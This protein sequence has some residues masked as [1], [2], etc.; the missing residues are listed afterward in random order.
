MIGDGGEKHYRLS[1]RFDRRG[2]APRIELS[3]DDGSLVTDDEDKKSEQRTLLPETLYTELCLY[4]ELTHRRPGDVI[5]MLLIDFL[6]PGTAPPPDPRSLTD[7]LTERADAAAARFRT[8][9]LYP[10]APLEEYQTPEERKTTP[11][12]QD[13]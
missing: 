2:P 8:R 9:K 13:T 12:K 3:R 6:R 10:P 7:L 11:G 4:A 1:L 5:R